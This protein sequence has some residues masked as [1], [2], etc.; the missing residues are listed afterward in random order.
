MAQSNSINNRWIE[1]KRL[2][3]YESISFVIRI[4][5]SIKNSVLLYGIRNKKS[6]SALIPVAIQL[7]NNLN[8]KFK[9][10]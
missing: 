9:F 10:A 1:A 7:I 3:Y 2:A 6:S 5:L 4:G 8:F